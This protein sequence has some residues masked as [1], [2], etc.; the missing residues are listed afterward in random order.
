MNCERHYSEIIWR[1]E[2]EIQKALTKYDICGLAVVLVDGDK[3]IWSKGYGYTDRKQKEVITPETLFSI[4]SMTK[5]F[6]A[7]AFQI[8]A[9]KGLIQLDDPI[10][11]Y[12]PN[13]SVK[14]QF[15]EPEKEIAKL[16]FR[17]MLSHWASFTHEAPVGN[18]YDDQ[19]CTFEDHVKSIQET[20]LRAPVGSE[21]TY[22]NL[23]VDLAGYVMGLIEEKTYPE[24][25]Q[26][27]LFEPLGIKN[28]TFDI[29]EALKQSFAKGHIGDFQTPTVQIPM[30]PSG[31]LYISTLDIAKFVS[32][33][34]QKGKVDGKQ[35]LKK[36]QY[37][38]MYQI[39]FLEGKKE[40]FGLSIYKNRE[41]SGKAVWEHGGGGYGYQTNMAWIPE[42][43]IGVIILINDMNHQSVQVEL[44]YKAL[45]L[46]LEA[47]E[48][49]TSEVQI[50][51]EKMKLLDGSYIA[52]RQP[53]TVITYENDSLYS[54]NSNDETR[55]LYPEST[56]EFLTKENKKYSF[57][58]GEDGR[59][60]KLVITEKD[61]PPVVV[62]YNDGPNDQKGAFQKEWDEYLGVYEYECYGRTGYHALGKKNGNLYLYSPTPNKMKHL[63][64]LVFSNADGEI[65]ELSKEKATYQ[66]IPLK[67]TTLQLDEILTKLEK[68]RKYLVA[69]RFPMIELTLIVNYLKGLKAALAFAERLVDLREENKIIIEYLG[70]L[71]F[72]DGD[73][74]KAE[75]CYQK[76][77]E[78][79]PKN[80]KAIELLEKIKIRKKAN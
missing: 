8:M 39:Q 15:G 22:S 37:E 5:S 52:E 47:K 57:I 36:E 32:F 29:Q 25:M 54:H 9:S 23:G 40:G 74:P 30:I 6:T 79:D 44:S 51:S 50:S 21:R 7:T 67:K 20:W 66:N 1:F 59:P 28:A 16:T 11:K 69:V 13:F 53:Y 45:Q 35:L 64:G 70:K 46:L 31:G 76:L 34:L 27:Y 55:K 56:T 68:D 77:L 17:R 10:R 73:L 71:L 38:E 3:V 58:L 42:D 4:Q 78:I 43:G 18:N 65:L 26:D 61:K 19:P 33:H 80:E 48:V 72:L 62:K 12:Y 24:V 14:V 75:N 2:T 63:E 49:P 60:K 41:I